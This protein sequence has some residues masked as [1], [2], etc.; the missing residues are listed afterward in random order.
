MYTE[1]TTTNHYMTVLQ[2]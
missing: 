2:A 1:S